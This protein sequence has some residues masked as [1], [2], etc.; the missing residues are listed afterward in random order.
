M[1]KGESPRGEHRSSALWGTEDRRGQSRS[2]ALWGK[3]GRGLVTALV[4]VLVVGAPL[5]AADR[6]EGR[7]QRQPVVASTTYVDPILVA[8]AKMT[9]EEFVRVPALAVDPSAVPIP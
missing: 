2:N 4:A 1:N 3:G 7:K 8:K 6:K 5:A 9:P